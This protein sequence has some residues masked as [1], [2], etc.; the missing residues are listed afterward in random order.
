MFTYCF[1]YKADAVDRSGLTSRATPTDNR[2]TLDDRQHDQVLVKPT[3]ES[4]AVDRSG[5]TSRA[6]PTDN[7]PTLDDRQ[8]DQVLVKPTAESAAVDADACADLR[9]CRDNMNRR[10]PDGTFVI[11]FL[12][13]RPYSAEPWNFVWQA[14]CKPLCVSEEPHPS[15]GDPVDL[16]LAVQELNTTDLE[17]KTSI[18][19][20]KPKVDQRAQGLNGCW[21]KQP[22]MV[23]KQCPSLPLIF[24]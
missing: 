5:L 9:R 11:F 20:P 19:N 24:F 10:L 16:D 6:T 3:A 21:D 2:P 22:R 12:T 17:E 13:D 23:H 7:R 1:H 8:H 15:R 4:D 14:S 18:K